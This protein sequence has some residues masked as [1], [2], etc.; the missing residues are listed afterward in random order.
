ML[1]Y[2]LLAGLL[3]S[4]GVHAVTCNSG[5]NNQV[6][7]TITANLTSSEN[8]QGKTLASSNVVSQGATVTFSPG[9]VGYWAIYGNEAVPA[10]GSNPGT[11]QFYK[12]DD[13]ISVALKYSFSCGDYYYPFNRA[14]LLTGDCSVSNHPTTTTQTLQDFQY[15]SQIRIDKKIVSGTYTKNIFL[16]TDG[17]CQPY[18][19]ANKSV[20]LNNIYLNLNITVPQSC[21]LNAGQVVTVDFGNISSSAFNTA[22]AKPVGVN[23]I[24]RSI[25][26]QCDN[27]AASTAMTMRLQANNVSGNAVV[28]DNS[29]VGFIVADSGGNPLTPNSL[30]SVIPFVLDSSE[31]ANVTIRVYPVSI[32]G[33]K[34]SEGTVT[35]QAY[36]RVDFA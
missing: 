15:Q 16:G 13:Y 26:V 1:K 36:L 2:I 11:W 17:M 35:S 8:Q 9:T 28:S 33:N 20:T 5:C 24:T 4:G 23:A 7:T 27:I 22:G 6:N 10:A 3:L 25:T 30:S 19:C 32:T 29:D 21:V 31:Q 12:V 18:G 14:G 34:P